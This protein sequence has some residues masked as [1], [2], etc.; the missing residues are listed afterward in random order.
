MPSAGPSS[1]WVA[2]YPGSPLGQEDDQMISSNQAVPS[3]SE[4]VESS[5]SSVPDLD[6]AVSEANSEE[7]LEWSPS[8]RASPVPAVT[9][10]DLPYAGEF[11]TLCD[12][13]ADSPAINGLDPHP[14]DVDCWE[15][16]ISPAE[17]LLR[18]KDTL[19]TVQI[20][21][22]AP[23]R[24][25]HTTYHRGPGFD[26]WLLLAQANHQLWVDP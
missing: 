8:P 23:L 2:P 22:R 12:L 14:V 10:L 5:A 24:R 4:Y 17:Y 3:G 21:S 13:S 9:N 16:V 26:R 18:F 15:L 25:L 19:A 20:I 6:Q 1:P 11:S 7:L